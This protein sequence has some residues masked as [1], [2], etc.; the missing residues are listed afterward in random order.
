MVMA[1]RRY[2]VIQFHCSLTSILKTEGDT[3]GLRLAFAT[4]GEQLQQAGKVE[5]SSI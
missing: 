4:F 5:V 2:Q 1:L 3:K